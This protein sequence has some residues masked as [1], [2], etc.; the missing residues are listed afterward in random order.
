MCSCLKTKLPL[1]R[2]GSFDRKLKQVV[3]ALS[4][5]PELWLHV[6]SSC[7][8]LL[9]MQCAVA[10][11][12]HQ[13]SRPPNPAQRF[14]SERALPFKGYAN[15]LFNRKNKAPPAGSHLGKSRLC[16]GSRFS[17]TRVSP[18]QSLPAFGPDRPRGWGLAC[19][20]W[21]VWQHPWSS[22]LDACCRCPRPPRCDNQNVSR[23]Y[24]CPLG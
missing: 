19:A 23:H 21:D 7:L 10:V 5:F 22:P 3:E 11:S 15:S 6:P 9:K 18:S 17:W 20:L 24:G 13:A 14:R 16:S 4:S 12:P 8:R 1:Q 2:C